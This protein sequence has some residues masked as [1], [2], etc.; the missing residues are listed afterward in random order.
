MALA[1]ALHAALAEVVGKAQNTA[2]VEFVLV[3]DSRL[4][5]LCSAAFHESCDNMSVPT[6]VLLLDDSQSN[7]VGGYTTVPW[8][9]DSNC[10]TPDPSSLLFQLCG[11]PAAYRVKTFAP[12]SPSAGIYSGYGHGPVFGKGMQASSQQVTCLT[13]SVCSL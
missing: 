9:G 2:S 1:K 3:Y 7:A 5:G 8:R 4:S 6:L 13:C 12:V 10:F 11:S